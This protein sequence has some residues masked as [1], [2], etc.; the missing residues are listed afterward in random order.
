MEKWVVAITGATGSIYAYKLLKALKEADIN[1]FLIITEP[2]RRVVRDELGWDLTGDP[3]IDEEKIRGYLGYE[4][5]DDSLS[6]YHWMDI[7]CCLASGSFPTHGMFVV[8]CTMATLAG[9]AHGMS[10]NLVERA[11]DVTL[12][13]KRPLVLVPRET[14]LN[15][16][17]LRNMLALAELGVHIVP[18][19]PA[20]YF[21]PRTIED[22]VDF[23]VAR[24]LNLVGIRCE[25]VLEWET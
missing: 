20:F 13:E 6:C 10:R 9:I 24:L 11:A 23:F 22:L 12:K 16:I 2:G 21:G 14:P 19:V 18:P 5:G 8:P 15:A 17:H 4:P 7:G 1:I 3:E 25:S